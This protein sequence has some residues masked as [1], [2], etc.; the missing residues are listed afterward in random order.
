MNKTRI[1]LIVVLVLLVL[2]GV[3][4]GIF[5]FFLPK[6]AGL[7]VETN[8]VSTVFVN[9]EEMGRTPYKI[10]LSQGEITLKLVPDSFGSPLI[11]Y[12]TKVEL[13]AGVDTVVR[14]IFDSTDEYSQGEIIS[15]NK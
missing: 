8:P 13:V 4:L 5:T 9:G 14:R 10:T 7:T 6:K 2:A 15:F 11:P 12:E 1:I 3:A